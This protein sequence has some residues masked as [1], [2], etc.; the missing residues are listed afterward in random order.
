MGNGG[1]DRF[2]GVAG[3]ELQPGDVPGVLIA[4]LLQQFQTGFEAVTAFA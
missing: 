4:S 1:L 2:I 3:F